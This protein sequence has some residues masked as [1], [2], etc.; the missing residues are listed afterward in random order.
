MKINGGHF[1]ADGNAVNVDVGF[2][3]DMVIAWE[4]MEETSPSMHTW[5]KE[6]ANTA[7]ANAQYGL[8][9]TGTSGIVTKHA[10]ATNGF[11]SEDM[12]KKALCALVDHATTSL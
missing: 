11:I 12:F 5:F 2:V 3:P 10:A 7:N 1:I 4:G 6:Q 9:L 8:I